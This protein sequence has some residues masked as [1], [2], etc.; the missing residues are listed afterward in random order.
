MKKSII[1]ILLFVGF[2]L[3]AIAQNSEEEKVMAQVANFVEKVEKN[4][5]TKWTDTEKAAYIEAKKVQILEYR[6]IWKEIKDEE[7]KKE[8]MQAAN[9]TF[10]ITL[11]EAFGGDK[12]RAWDIINAG[13]KKD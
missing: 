9:K 1:L 12:K 4:L 7:L 5:E 6:R 8:S 10:Q 3:N 13:N 11:F 2:S